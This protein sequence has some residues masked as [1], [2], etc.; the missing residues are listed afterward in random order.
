M[1]LT[2]GD[3]EAKFFGGLGVFT[4]AESLTSK[5]TVCG[6]LHSMAYFDDS[7]CREPDCPQPVIYLRQKSVT[8]LQR[9]IH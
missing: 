8:H 7:G 2:V 9:C 6:M 4:D 3:R 5:V 1:T